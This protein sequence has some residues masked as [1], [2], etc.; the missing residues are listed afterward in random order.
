MYLSDAIHHYGSKDGIY[1]A[2]LS[3]RDISK[4]TVYM[5]K[6]HVPEH[7]ARELHLLSRRK[8]PLHMEHYR[9]PPRKPARARK[10]R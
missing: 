8:I 2:I 5:W 4:S 9:L 1:R 3:L 6:E 10:T 7:W